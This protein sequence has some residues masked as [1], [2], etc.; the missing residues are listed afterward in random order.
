MS[1]DKQAIDNMRA[2]MGTL[3]SRKPEKNYDIK[4]AITSINVNMVASHANPYKALVAMAAATWGSGK[5]EYGE[6]ST[7]K[8][9]KLTPEN[10]YSIVKAVLTGNTLPTALEAVNFTF[11]VNGTPRHTFDQFAR[12]R[13]GIG[14]GSIGSRDNNKLDAPFLLYDELLSDL[15]KDPELY[16]RFREWT[17]MTKDLYE[18]LMGTTNGSWQTARAVLPMCYNHSFVFNANL[19]AIRGQCA[20]RLMACEEGPICALMWLIRQRILEQFPLLS[21]GLRPA[22]DKARKCVYHEGPEG[23]TKYFSALFAGCGRWKTEQAYSE[24]NHSCTS[25]ERLAELGIPVRSVEHLNAWEQ[26]ML[27]GY[28]ELYASDMLLF[29]ED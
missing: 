15:E 24:F 7:G 23:L 1:N 27:S 13:V 3:P 25:Y 26:R 22:C 18:S 29:V 10:R 19:M 12:A 4:N 14:F 5:T 6:G 2:A 11:E 20:R 21:V 28:N 8:W 16:R 9:R 17:M